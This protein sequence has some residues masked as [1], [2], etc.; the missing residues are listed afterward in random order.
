MIKSEHIKGIEEALELKLLPF[1]IHY[2]IGQSNTLGSTRASGRTTAYCIKLAL[3]EGE[4]LNLRETETFA[5]MRHFPVHQHMTYSRSFF[6]NVFMDIR[7]KL[8][9]YGFKVREVK[10]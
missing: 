4:P 2:I 6:R 10:Y 9:E 1:Q 8:E 5:D 7:G 3:S